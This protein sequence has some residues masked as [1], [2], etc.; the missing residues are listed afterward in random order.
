MSYR[1]CW[2]VVSGISMELHPDPTDKQSAK[3]VWHTPIAVYTVLDSW[4]WKENLS[5]TCRVLSKNKFGKLVQLVGFIWRRYHDARS[6][7]YKIRHVTCCSWKFYSRT[8]RK[9]E[10]K[11]NIRCNIYA[12]QLV[13]SQNIDWGVGP[14]Q[15]WIHI[16]FLNTKAMKGI[17]IASNVRFCRQET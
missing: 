1:F 5:E 13:C 6:S 10:Q 4:W 16:Q 9:N 11:Q 2:L 17:L 12:T 3:P 8:S 7:E 15:N 14:T